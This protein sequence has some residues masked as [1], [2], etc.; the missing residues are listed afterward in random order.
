MFNVQFSVFGIFFSGFL[1]FSCI[2]SVFSGH[3]VIIDSTSGI[4]LL[5]VTVWAGFDRVPKCQKIKKKYIQKKRNQQI[6]L[7]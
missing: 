1:Q 2:L 6:D 3:A 5:K 4:G 7:E